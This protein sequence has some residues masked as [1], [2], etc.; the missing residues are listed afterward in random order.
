MT[1]LR[2][3]TPLSELIPQPKMDLLL[4]NKPRAGGRNNTGSI[5]FRR[6]GGGSKKFL[7][8]VDFKKIFWNIPFYVLHSV[9]DPTRTGYLFLACFINGIVTYVLA[10]EGVDDSQCFLTTSK[11]GFFFVGNTVTLSRVFEGCFIHSLEKRLNFGGTIARSAG[12]HAT[13][14][15]KFKYNQILIRLPS[16]EEILIGEKTITTLGRVSNI[17]HKFIRLTGAGQLRRL[18]VRPVVR[19]VA[20]NPVDHPH[21]GAGGKPQV[22]AWSKIAK[23]KN[24]R[25]VKIFVNSFI[26]LSR[27]KLKKKIRK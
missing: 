27:K 13:L 6:S 26:F 23:N 25:K 10:T 16:K 17:N 4:E 20:R 11:P 15:K 18:G 21:G 8:L 24:T 7:R 19:G 22:T 2:I 14:L 9:K 5:V 1:Y 12:T 3:R